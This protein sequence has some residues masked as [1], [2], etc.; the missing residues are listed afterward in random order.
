MSRKRFFRSINGMFPFVL[1]TYK[2]FFG[3]R[4]IKAP[5]VFFRDLFFYN[6]KNK[7]NKKFKLRFKNI[8]PIFYD[9]YEQA[10]DIVLHYFFQ[11]IWA[12]KKVKDSGVDI[13][14]DIGSRLDGFISH[15][16]V[17][18]DVVMLDIR[19]LDKEIKGL[20]FIK[21]DCTN[22]ENI[23]TGSVE[24]LSSLHAVE[25]F[26]LGRYGDDI[27]PDGYVKVIKEMQRIVKSGGSIYFSTPIGMERLEFNAHRIFNPKYIIDLFD[28]CNLAE[29][30]AVDDNNV[31]T[32][33]ADI[34]N[35]LDKDFS[36]G[37][38]HFVKK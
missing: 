14:Y 24:S 6:K 26:G 20:S 12:A 23:N 1:P 30:S 22:M 19:P 13:H 33:N 7:K 28:Q 9:R 29:F 8:F 31:F 35:F 36:C 25:H 37:L 17:F 16:L 34:D 38:Y 11:D 27:D 4:F 32:K 2:V 21:C 18:C 3:F 15:C 5:F 10:G